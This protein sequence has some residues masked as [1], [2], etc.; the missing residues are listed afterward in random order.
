[1][2]S[3]AHVVHAEERVESLIEPVLECNMADSSGKRPNFLVVV[4]DELGFSD[5]ACFGSVSRTRNIDK[6]GHIG[7]EYNS[8]HAAA[9]CL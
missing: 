8:I 5:C 7:V 6:F 9:A 2:K 4:A 3:R 1:M